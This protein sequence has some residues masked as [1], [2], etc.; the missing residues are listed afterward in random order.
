MTA[1]PMNI[2]FLFCRMMTSLSTCRE[3]LKKSGPG[4]RRLPCL[5]LALTVSL[6]CVSFAQIQKNPI[7]FGN[8]K[9]ETPPTLS[10][11]TAT[12]LPNGRWLLLGGEKDDVAQSLATLVDTA[13]GDASPLP[14]PL[15]HARAWHTATV[16]P[17]GRVLILGGI[18]ED[19]L[20]VD[21][22]EVFD[23]TDFTF[24]VLPQLDLTPRTHHTSTLLTD[25]HVLIT[26][27]LSDG[28]MPID[29][30]ETWDFT[31]GS[32]EKL[33]AEL[34]P[35]RYAHEAVLVPNE[36]VLLWGGYDTTDQSISNADFYLPSKKGFVTLDNQTANLL[37]AS[38]YKMANPAVSDSVPRT[39]AIN[40]PIDSFITVR[41]NKPL[42]PETL[43]SDT[44]ILFGPFGRVACQVTAAEEGLLL[45]VSPKAEMLPATNYTLF[46]QGAQDDAGQALPFTTLDFETEALASVT[47]ARAS[48]KAAGQ[49]SSGQAKASATTAKSNPDAANG[50]A[51]PQAKQGAVPAEPAVEADDESWAPGHDN[52]RGNWRS[53]RGTSQFQKLPPLQAPLGV[54]ALAGQVLCLNGM[55]LADIT[56][57]VGGKT[58]HSDQSGRFLLSDI[59]AGRQVLVIDGHSANHGNK[60]YG[61]FEVKVEPEAGKTLVLDYTIWMPVLDTK[62]AVSLASPTVDEAVVA[63]PNIP[64]LE[65]RIPPGTVIR[66][67]DGNVVTQVSITA[68]PID[69][70]PFPLPPSAVPVYFSIQPGG[71]YLQT[72]NAQSAAGA[73]VIYPNFTQDAPGTLMEFWNYDPMEK[74]WYVYGQGRVSE[75]GKQVMPDPGVAIYEFSGAMIT[76]PGATPPANAPPAGAQTGL[77]GLAG[78][79][80]GSGA[81]GKGG[82]NGKSG[83]PP[84]NGGKGGGPCG[85]PAKGG[86]PVDLATGLFVYEKTDLMI[87]DTL[88]LM[89]SRTYRNGDSAVRAFGR[90]TN[91]DYGIFMWSAQ[92][93]Q[94]ADLVLPDGAKIHFV[95]TSAGTGF[96]NA[97]FECTA[98]STAFYKSKM[99]WN[100][101]GWDLTLKDGTVYVFGENRP[102]Q[103]IRD[104]YGNTV[105]LT[106]S[107]G[108]QSGNIT[109]I[110][111]PNGRWI[112]FSYDGNNRITQ[113]TDNIGRSVT[114]TYDT[115]GRLWQV[116]DPAGGVTEYTYDSSHR[117]LT[118]KDPKGIVYLTNVYDSNGRVIH[119]TLADSGTYQFVYTL[120]GNGKVT[121][122]DVTD[123]LGVVRRVTFNAAGYPLT[124]TWAYGTAEQQT[125][126]YT[127]DAV[128]QRLVSSTDPLSRVTAYEYDTAGNVNRVTRLSGTANAVAT[129]YTYEPN[130]N[131]IASVT[132]PLGHSAQFAYDSRGNL[133]TATDPLGRQSSFTYNTDGRL[134]TA[135]DPLG[136]TSQFSYDGG[137]LVAVI[138]PLG[139]QVT[140]HTDSLGRVIASDDVLG[141]RSWI[142]YDAMGRVARTTDSLGRVTEINYDANGNLTSVTDARGGV[143][144]YSYDD[145]DRQI[146]RTDPLGKSESYSYDKNDN[147]VSY[148]DRRGQVSEYG[149]DA[150]NRRTLA[151]YGATGGTY[152]SQV[153]YTYDADNRL[154]QATDSQSG[155]ISRTYDNLNRMTGETTPQGSVSYAYDDAGRRTELTVTGQTA[156]SYGYDAANRLTSITQGSDAVGY[157]YDDAG[158]RTSLTLPNGVIVDYGYD[159][160][161]QLLSLTYRKGGTIL[162]DL[163]YEY[164]AVG[165]RTAVGGSYADTGLPATLS[166]TTY[167]ANNRL[168]VR[169]GTALSYDD[170]GSMTADGTYNYSWDERNRLTQI[171]QG[172]NTVA[173]FAY[174]LF[175]RRI[176]KT[177]RGTTINYL[178]DGLNLALELN[179]M[180]PAATYLAGPGI[181]EVYRR[182]DINGARYFLSDALGSTLALT[183]GTGTVQTRYTY[184]PFGQTTA[185]GQS[186]GNPIQYTGRENDNTGLYYYRA[187]YY[188][189]GLQRF[190][191]EDP[192]GLAGGINSYTYVLN[193]PLRYIDPLGLET[194]V[195]VWQPVGWGGSSFGHVSTDINGTTYS[196]GPSG[197]AILPT[198]DYL[199]K[200]SFRDGTGVKLNINP[201]QEKS[202][203]AC[204][205]KPQGNYNAL[206]N[207]C[208]TPI[209]SCLKDQG[210]DTG[211]QTL[212]VSLGNQLLD[213]GIVNGVQNYPATTPANGSS[214]PWAR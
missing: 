49:Q 98:S 2:V 140:R 121:Q 89:V 156:V 112:E 21:E 181:D 111:S 91:F 65:L 55:P 128:T 173:S 78:G 144:S 69:R 176:G 177:M 196:Y 11:Q 57:N 143:T 170:N 132:D 18:G 19:G 80:S 58:A 16:L 74:G 209:Q 162:G 108:G 102:L 157:A 136:N 103:A 114:Y 148:V 20:I 50:N 101:L 27:G 153:T 180:T 34:L 64:G 206:T 79:S 212:P 172:G 67:R 24:H 76:V 137:D 75:D 145:K 135:T 22:A 37:P 43:N 166:A 61:V 110:T 84:C 211:N 51:Q 197:M 105:T 191:S 194:T 214:A 70:P 167:D 38:P 17:D 189:P 165:R 159:N 149:Y 168:T 183:D 188:H 1:Y 208:G 185:S 179:G 190:I 147:L 152:A 68:I 87:A 100:G 205:S 60:T 35:A 151:G 5:I 175:G 26:G 45:F 118:V 86:E 204:L 199:S 161:N 6:P 81:S 119:Q 8:L 36:N 198:P 184:D 192:I 109:R 54:T 139:N 4:L 97:V 178:Y 59:P 141:N 53:G 154:T 155:T 32:V 73:R 130:Y 52:F 123:P 92:Q 9:R 160:A 88:P 195:Y 201:Q 164:D 29:T 150:L 44:V 124:D 63:T 40:V 126:S 158:R 47:G 203:Q 82:G 99:V 174:D 66:D 131:Q 15:K 77:P 72:I 10:G 122:T 200:N 202:I 28:N 207:N 93:Y 116:T 85:E 133:V 25:G 213:M 107:S 42:Q 94:E 33:N 193:N 12:L 146:T 210:V 182:T 23:S 31:S 120:N 30:A 13:T 56:L 115:S 83:R 41:F 142:A 7:E 129:N 96:T 187:R 48:A 39:D 104:R 186:S 171:S 106:R 134:V 62:H 125:W 46:I 3:Q 163:S 71:A 113:A 127:R 138:D 95:R 117:L 169:G 90:G 14:A